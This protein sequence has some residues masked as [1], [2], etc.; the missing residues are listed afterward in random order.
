V[1]E[2]VG[3][4]FGHAPLNRLVLATDDAQRA[5]RCGQVARVWLLLL[6]GDHD[7]NEVKVGKLPGFE[8][9]FR[10]ATFAEIEDHFGCKPG[11]LG[12]CELEKAVQSAWPTAMW[13]S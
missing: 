10:F 9:G 13:R 4:A 1:A 3:F 8:S 12:P 11:Y 5:G 6:R 2:L 7:M